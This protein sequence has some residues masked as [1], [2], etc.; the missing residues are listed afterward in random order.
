MKLKNTKEEFNV[1][2]LKKELDNQ[3]QTNNAVTKN[4]KL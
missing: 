1:L 2:I 4:P 3:L